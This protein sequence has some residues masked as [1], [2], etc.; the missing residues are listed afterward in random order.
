MPVANLRDLFATQLNAAGPVIQHYEVI[1]SA[2]H[3]R[4][5]QHNI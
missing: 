5:S 2:V 4:E 1:A 3:L